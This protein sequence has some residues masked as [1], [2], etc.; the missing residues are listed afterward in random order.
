MM[1]AMTLDMGEKNE[2]NVWGLGEELAMKFCK[3]TRSFQS[4]ETVL[5][6]LKVEKNVE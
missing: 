5:H 4:V 1:K 2:K 6:F 3:S